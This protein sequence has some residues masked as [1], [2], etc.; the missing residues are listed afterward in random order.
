M[1]KKIPRTLKGHIRA[2]GYLIYLF[3]C[4]MSEIFTGTYA[5]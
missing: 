1:V 4:N 2:Q 5:V 3:Q